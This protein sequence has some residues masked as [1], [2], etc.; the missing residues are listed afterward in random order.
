MRDWSEA[1]KSRDG[2]GRGWAER[3]FNVSGIIYSPSTMLLKINERR[4]VVCVFLNNE[5]K[6]YICKR[7]FKKDKVKKPLSLSRSEKKQDLW[8]KCKSRTGL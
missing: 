3:F 1:R 2:R 5:N 8:G 6:G 4:N 7:Q